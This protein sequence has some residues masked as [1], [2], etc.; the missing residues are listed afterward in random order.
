[1]NAL[2]RHGP[3]LTVL[4]KDGLNCGLVAEKEIEVRDDNGTITRYLMEPRGGESDTDGASDPWISQAISHLL[5]LN[6]DPYGDYWPGAVF[7]DLL[8]RRLLKQWFNGQWC[9]FQIAHVR[10]GYRH[11]SGD[12]Y[13]PG[14]GTVR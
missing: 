9:N 14:F 2:F 8:Y 11:G 3:Q 7:H 6:I 10:A 13:L 12:D 4:T 5:G 1:L